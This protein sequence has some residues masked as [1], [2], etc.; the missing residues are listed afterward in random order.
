MKEKG[1]KPH[2]DA[3]HTNEYTV[4]L[5][6]RRRNQHNHNL[7]TPRENKIGNFTYIAKATNKITELLKETHI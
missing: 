7:F 6:T 5:G 4:N 1:T 2:N 3:L